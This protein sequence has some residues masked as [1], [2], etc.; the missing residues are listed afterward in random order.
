VTDELLQPQLL[1]GYE[2]W[3]TD[4][5][6]KMMMNYGEPKRA[7]VMKDVKKTCAEGHGF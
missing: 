6:W 5:C 4:V 2:A 3:K 7:Y 1:D